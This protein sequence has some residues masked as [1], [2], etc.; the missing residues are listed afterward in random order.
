M[1]A[2]FIM[3]R[4]PAACLAT[5]LASCVC[6]Q[7]HVEADF[8]EH[9]YT[10]VGGH[11]EINAWWR[12]GDASFNTALNP[13]LMAHTG[14]AAGGEIRLGFIRPPGK[15]ASVVV[16]ELAMEDRRG[17]PVAVGV[18][19]PLR[20]PFKKED[21]PICGVKDQEGPV[22][23]H[24]AEFTIRPEVSIAA[25]PYRITLRGYYRRSGG[26]KERIDTR[27]VMDLK[28]ERDFSSIVECWP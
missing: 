19:L 27:I 11:R 18:A 24:Y 25:A 13:A 23:K 9:N 12:E 5:S 21:F 14:S 6:Y 7:S 28:R 4:L 2:A 17:K 3:A 16:E 20:L 10:N 1:N 15:D 8:H 22:M 26:A